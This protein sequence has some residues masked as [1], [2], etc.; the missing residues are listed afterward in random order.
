MQNRNLFEQYAKGVFTR[1]S[2][3][4]WLFLF[5]VCLLILD[6][7]A[8]CKSVSHDN[9]WLSSFC[10]ALGS[11]DRVFILTSLWFSFFITLIPSLISNRIIRIILIVLELL[12]LMAFY[13]SDIYLMDAYKMPF[14]ESIAFAIMATNPAEAKEFF[15]IV[16]FKE[17][18]VITQAIQLF[19]AVLLSIGIQIGANYLLYKRCKNRKDKTSSTPKG[20]IA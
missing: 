7:I 5:I 16:T 10:E 8:T 13:V 11:G 14:N 18:I 1:L 12:V 3:S 6:Q 20:V 4:I 19:I 15:S 17:S 2:H 9:G